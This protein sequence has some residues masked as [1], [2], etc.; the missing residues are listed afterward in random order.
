MK[1]AFFPGLREA[2][3]FVV[4]A[5]PEIVFEHRTLWRQLSPFYSVPYESFRTAVHRGCRDGLLATTLCGRRPALLSTQPA[6]AEVATEFDLRKLRKPK[7]DGVWR[8]LSFDIPERRRRDRDLLRRRLSELGYGMLHQS[9]WISPHDLALLTRRLVDEQGLSGHVW[10]FHARLEK[11][12]IPYQVTRAAWPH[13]DAIGT[14]YG[15]YADRWT[16]ALKSLPLKADPLTLEVAHQLARFQLA[17]I[18]RKDPQLPKALLPSDW[19]MNRALACLRQV[20]RRVR[21]R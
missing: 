14:A 10:L 13:L 7:W 1:Q 17:A 3:I 12:R 5:L 4:S 6:R 15:Q 11:G 9:L 8:L 20:S 16:E 19:P 2:V 21:H 18:L